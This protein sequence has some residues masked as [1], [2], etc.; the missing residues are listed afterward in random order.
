MARPEPNICSQK[1]GNG[2]VCACASICTVSCAKEGRRAARKKRRAN[3]KLRQRLEC[4]IRNSFTL[5]VRL[6]HSSGEMLEMRAEDKLS[7]ARGVSMDSNSH[8]CY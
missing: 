1:C 7:S 5:R 3:V 2:A 4:C 6:R 8:Q